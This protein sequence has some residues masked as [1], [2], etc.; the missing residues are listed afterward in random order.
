VRADSRK[1]RGREKAESVLCVHAYR[2]AVELLTV[3]EHSPPSSGLT[4]KG[5]ESR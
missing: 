4:L 1:E 5:H 3:E 2:K